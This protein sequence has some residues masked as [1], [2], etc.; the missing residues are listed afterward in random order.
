MLLWFA[1]GTA[2][3]ILELFTPTFIIM[4]FGLGA[5]G[6]ALTAYF[7]PGITQE[8]IAFVI[9]T[10]VSLFLLRAKMKNVFQGFQAGESKNPVTQNFE[11]LGKTVRV[12]KT[13]SPHQEG[14][15]FVG[16]SYWRATSSATLPKDALAI[17][18][19]QDK[20][21]KLLL[22]VQAQSE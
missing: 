14:E 8:L 22:V 19:S 17:I 15:V 18:E 13:I 21:D 3:I 9:V 11:Y 7:Y 2:L 4:F 20:N 6:A 16:G 5:W 1:L 12:T 10:L